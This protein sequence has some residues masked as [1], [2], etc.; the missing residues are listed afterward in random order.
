MSKFMLLFRSDP[1]ARLS[2]SPEEMQQAM[3]Q[4]MAW[5]ESLQKSGHA[6]T[7]GDRLDSRGVVVRGMAKTVNDGPYVEVKDAVQGFMLLEAA[8]IEQAVE[9]S[10]GCPA[11]EMD[12][13][14][15]IRPIF[16]M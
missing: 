14:V 1:S 5:M 11:L 6:P 10:K 2:L 4:W 15:E 13:S 12:G 9:L 3:K 8:D 7:A 16:F